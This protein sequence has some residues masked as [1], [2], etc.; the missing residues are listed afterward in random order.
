Y[1]STRAREV[2]IEKLRH[3]QATGQAVE[4]EVLTGE[5]ARAREPALADTVAAAIVLQGQR[6]IDPRRFVHALGDAVRAR[7][8]DL[9]EGL[10]ARDVRD[11][12]SEAGVEIKSGE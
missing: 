5:E 11:D 3:I 6:F 1:R 9:R 12:G 10:E 4:F 2:M 8:G 7:G